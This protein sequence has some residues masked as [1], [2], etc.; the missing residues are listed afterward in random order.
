MTQRTK[1]IMDGGSGLNLMY[2]N[3]FE[4]LGL[5][6]DQLKTTWLPFYGVVL[7]KQ[8]IPLGQ[9]SLPITFGDASNYCTGPYHIILG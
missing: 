3:T 8:T 6:W 7:G 2:L 9:I 5:A 1:A 4:G